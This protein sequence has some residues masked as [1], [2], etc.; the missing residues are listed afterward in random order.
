MF[1]H[2]FRD[3]LRRF[4]EAELAPHADHIDRDNGWP[5]FRDFW[6]K[7]GEMGLLGITA[8]GESI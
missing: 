8:P 7:L 5:E 1:D 6:K 3:M 2:Q 4:C